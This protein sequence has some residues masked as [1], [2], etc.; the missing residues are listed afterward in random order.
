M[1]LSH[2]EENQQKNLVK[3]LQNIEFKQLDNLEITKP[4]NIPYSVLMIELTDFNTEINIEL[5]LN[6]NSDGDIDDSDDDDDDDDDDK[7]IY[8]IVISILG[9]ILLIILLILIIKCI[10]KGKGNQD[11]EEKTQ[12]IKNEKLLQDI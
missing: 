11:I 3:E 10:Q 2:I 4:N 6:N 12:N 8:I 7:T 5:K 1:L 9:G